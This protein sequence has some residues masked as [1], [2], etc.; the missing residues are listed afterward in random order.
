MTVLSVDTT[1]K[2]ASVALYRNGS[3]F[4]EFSA[5]TNTHSKSILP[6]IESILK[7]NGVNY[8]DLDL[9]ASAAGPGSFTGI[10]IGISTVKGIS[11]ANGTPCCAV[12]SLEAIAMSSVC[13]DS[14][15]VP[16]IDAR[17]D[18]VYTSLF[19]HSRTAGL[20]RLTD[21]CQVSL[22]ELSVM[23][24]GLDGEVVISGD[25]A[26]KASEHMNRHVNITQPLHTASGL[27]LAAV[28]KWELTEDKSFFSDD[29]LQPVYLKI[30]QA[31]KELEGRDGK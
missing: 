1:S 17:N 14:Y 8:K 16:V 30:T 9:I 24:S 26:F 4:S 15:I 13:P 11:L 12:S 3:V 25:A 18:T 22:Q 28:A 23:V 31:E 6:M 21:D 10:R 5:V 19:R 27:A 20:E 2:T 29:N 7:V